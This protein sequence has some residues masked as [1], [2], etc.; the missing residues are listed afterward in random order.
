MHAGRHFSDEEKKDRWAHVVAPAGTDGVV[1]KR[2]ASGPAPVH[3]AL[4]MFAT[5]LSPSTTLTHKFPAAPKQRKAYVHVVQTSGYNPGKAAGAQ[6]RVCGAK[7]QELVMREGDGA[8]ILADAGA[9]LEVR[10]EG[11]RVAEVIL[12]DME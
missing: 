8:Y 4:S 1:E 10:N 2:E 11:D 9:V 7:G 6:V 3:S 12:F 5:L